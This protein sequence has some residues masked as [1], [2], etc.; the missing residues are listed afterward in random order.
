MK[1]PAFTTK[2]TKATKE[3]KT[4]SWQ[5]QLAVMRRMRTRKTEGSAKSDGRVPLTDSKLSAF[6]P[7]VSFVVE[8]ASL[9]ERMVG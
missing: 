9:V 7:F 3:E 4:V 8:N 6:V 5:R 2:D 1:V